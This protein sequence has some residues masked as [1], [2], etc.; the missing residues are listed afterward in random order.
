M[1]EK[2]VRQYHTPKCMI[3]ELTEEMY[4]LGS[5]FPGQHNP[6]QHG[7][8]PSSAKA[9]DFCDDETNYASAEDC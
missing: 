9:A 3:I 2:K 1:N 5:S 7:S 6:A 8:G 4:L